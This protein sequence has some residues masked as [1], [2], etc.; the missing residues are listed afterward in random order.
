MSAFLA[1]WEQLKKDFDR[2]A[3]KVQNPDAETK[4]FL[5][6]MDKPFGFTP[7]LK[8]IDDAFKKGYRKPA[9]Q[10]LL[11]FYSHREPYSAIFTKAKVHRSHI[12]LEDPLMD[13]IN[14]F[15]SGIVKLEAAIQAELKNLQ[16]EKGPGGENPI[17][18]HLFEVDLQ[19]NIET[20]KK[21]L[22]PLAAID[23]KYD[24]LTLIQPAVKA[25]DTYTKAAARTQAQ[26]A[27]NALTSF[28]ALAK[29]CETEC[30]KILAKEKDPAYTA[31]VK[32]FTKDLVAMCSAR[33]NDQLKA[34]AKHLGV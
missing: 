10:G 17:Q 26:E 16:D 30:D 9:M 22:K 2:E 19:K 14:T 8:E 21:A 3:K 18:L 25:M 34:L 11:K 7:I 31:A 27:Y 24:V 1:K 29:K 20:A 6:L 5:A 33:V 23:K 4:A 28:V 15:S 13:A 12:D 32:R